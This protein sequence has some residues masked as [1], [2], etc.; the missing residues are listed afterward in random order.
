MKKN[1]FSING[2]TC[3]AAAMAFTTCTID[4]GFLTPNELLFDLK[5]AKADTYLPGTDIT[6]QLRN[7]LANGRNGQL[8]ADECQ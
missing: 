4:T 3:I 5:G 2:I 1:K 6:Y 7:N 8:M